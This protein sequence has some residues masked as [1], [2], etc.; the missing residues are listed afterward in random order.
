MATPMMGLPPCAQNAA[1]LEVSGAH[2]IAL[3]LQLG[4]TQQQKPADA[5]ALQSVCVLSILHTYSIQLIT[6]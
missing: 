2:G 5:W 1:Q 3:Y 6:E 4:S